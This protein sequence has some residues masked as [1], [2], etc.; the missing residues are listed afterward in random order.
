MICFFLDTCDEFVGYVGTSFGRSSITYKHYHILIYKLILRIRP[1]GTDSK[2]F[3]IEACDNP[4][5][6]AR[7]QSDICDRGLTILQ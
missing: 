3:L 7:V 1:T 2:V 4:L 6:I 5:S